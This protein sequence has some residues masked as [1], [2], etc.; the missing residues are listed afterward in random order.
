MTRV[1]AC[2]AWSNTL[3]WSTTL[4]V[5]ELK[6]HLRER[7]IDFSACL[8]KSELIT[9][10][11]S[12]KDDCE[13]TVSSS[14]LSKD[15]VLRVV[16][17]LL[18]NANI[19]PLATDVSRSAMDGDPPMEFLCPITHEPMVDPVIAADGHSYER[20]AIERWLRI[21]QKSPRTNARLKNKTLIPNF[22][23]KTLISDRRFT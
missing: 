19:P 2:D 9:L 13:T 17:D 20:A 22:A 4:T 14:S 6:S 11:R 18:R 7:D 10:L 3:T 15:E 5:G 23:L 8:E 12:H 1:N 16:N 21:K